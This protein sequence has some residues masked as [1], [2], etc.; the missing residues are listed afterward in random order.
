[1]V[2]GIVS[3]EHALSAAQAMGCDQFLIEEMIPDCVAEVLI[4]VVHDPVHGFVL[5]LA[6]GGVL[7]EVLQ[8]S[9]SLMVP[10]SRTDV[11]DA[12]SHLKIAKLLQGYRG[13]PPADTEAIIDT[14]MAVQ[15]FVLDHHDR[16]EEIEINPLFALP[17]GAIA[18][19]A[20]IRIGD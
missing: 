2:V 3:H 16:L 11:R 7:T 13:A 10:S 5:T 17:T 1:M 8:D 9:V 20:L 6:A 12:M 18:V 15:R 14:V 19:D 4:G